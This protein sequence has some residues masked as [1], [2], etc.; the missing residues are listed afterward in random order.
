MNR[1]VENSEKK[2]IY[3]YVEKLGGSNQKHNEWLNSL[4]VFKKRGACGI[5]HPKFTF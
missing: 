2:K 1:E 3:I 4:D 5:P